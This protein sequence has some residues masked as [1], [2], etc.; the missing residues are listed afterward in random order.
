MTV[1]LMPVDMALAQEANPSRALPAEVIRGETFN[2]T[3]NFT[4]PADNFFLI[5]LCDVAPEGWNVT[6]NK[7]W[8]TP[9]ATSAMGIGNEAQLSWAGPFSNGTFFTAVYKVVVSEDADTG[10][11]T[12]A[13]TLQ[14][15]F[16]GAG[17]YWEN[18]TGDSQVEIIGGTLEGNVTFVG[19]GGPGPK[20]VGSFNVALYE[21]GGTPTKTNALWIGSASTDTTG[22][23][24]ITGLYP[25][26]YD[27]GIK[28]RTSL[29]VLATDVTLTPGMTTVVDFGATREGDATNNDYI[30]ISDRTLL[31][32]AW[33]TGKGDPGWNPNCDFNRDEYLT[34]SDRTILYGNW[35]QNGDLGFRI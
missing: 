5:S 8:C 16:G 33:G 17:P 28:N 6:V 19:R 35:G 26:T 20:W 30:T 34:I 11:H 32:S 10:F 18:I 15:Y 4:A 25:G 29:T 7:T 31:Y 21:E 12:F 3:V 14:Y 24:T 13:G 9:V 23:F 27:I 22:V 1:V 2:V